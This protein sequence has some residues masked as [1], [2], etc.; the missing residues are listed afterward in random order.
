M[1]IMS[2]EGLRALPDC[3]QLKIEEARVAEYVREQRGAV[4]L[5]AARAVCAAEYGFASWENL[6]GYFRMCEAHTRAGTS[7][8]NLE[9][10]RA[11]QEVQSLLKDFNSRKDMTEPPPDSFGH[12]A[13]AATYVPRLYGLSDDELKTETLNDREAQ[14]VVARQRR[15]M[16]WNALHDKIGEMLKQQTPE[17]LRPTPEY[18]AAR[19]A[20]YANAQIAVRE[21]DIDG[22]SR[23]HSVIPNW[24]GPADGTGFTVGPVW[25]VIKQ[26]ITSQDAGSRA[27]LDHLY[28]LGVDVQSYLDSAIV[29]SGFGPVETVEIRGLLH[30]G[31]NV[32]QT[33]TDGFSLLEHAVVKYMNGE[34]VDLIAS[35]VAPRRAFWIAAGLGDVSTMMSFIDRDNRP[36]PEARGDRFDANALA[37][38]P[39]FFA[40]ASRPNASDTEILWEA[41]M[42]AGLNGRFSAL[43]ALLK[44]GFPINYAPGPENLLVMSVRHHLAPVVEYLLSRGADPHYKSWPNHWSAVDMSN[45]WQEHFAEKPGVAD[46]PGV[47]GIH[48]MLVGAR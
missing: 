13:A 10:A 48:A 3:P 45:V 32:L 18:I 23:A 46:R 30:L 8:M 11:D 4:P 36:T 33:P 31:A 41:F 6:I 37:M 20:E 22:L 24:F 47:R 35:R 7:G 28:A 40:S 21:R 39:I 15:F 5:E 42:L 44:L 16:N 29:G 14:L 2:A 9:K 25:D 19:K 38:S 17:Q 43:D 27:L 1:N 34:A 12:L 26:F